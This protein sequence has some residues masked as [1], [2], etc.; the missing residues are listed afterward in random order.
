MFCVHFSVQRYRGTGGWRASLYFGQDHE[1]HGAVVV[2]QRGDVVVAKS[3][4]R[5]SVDLRAIYTRRSFRLVM[6]TTA[7]IEKKNLGVDLVDVVVAWVVEVVAQRRGQHYQQVSAGEFIPQVRQPD[8]PVHLQGGDSRL[9]GC[10]AEPTLLTSLSVPCSHHLGDAEAVAEVME[11]DAV[12]V[13]VDLKQ[14]VLQDGQLD[15]QRC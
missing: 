13:A 3:Q 7:C 1:G 2:L 15:V 12:I 6:Y 5:L 8:Q 4:V 14:E 11:R 9:G 10:H